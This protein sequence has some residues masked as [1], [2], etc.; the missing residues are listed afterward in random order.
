[1]KSIIP[2]IIL[3]FIAGCTG[4]QNKNNKSSDKGSSEKNTRNLSLPKKS[5]ILEQGNRVKFWFTHLFTEI[6]A[7]EEWKQ[8][9]SVLITFNTLKMNYLLM[10]QP[11]GANS[12]PNALTS[13][14]IP[15]LV[16][17]VIF[18]FFHDPPTGKASKG[19]AYFSRKSE[20]R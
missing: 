1:M 7:R 5:I 15:M 17:M 9:Y 2:V 8:K 19:F 10:A 13:M 18:Y 3:L 4:Q 16:I 12:N 6:Q 11:S 14:L 20:E